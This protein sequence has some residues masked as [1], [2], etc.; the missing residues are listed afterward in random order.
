MCGVR[1]CYLVVEAIKD[2]AVVVGVAH[3]DVE[4]NRGGER[5]SAA[6][7][8]RQDE[9]EMVASL[10]VEG[11]RQADTNLVRSIDLFPTAQ[12]RIRLHSFAFVHGTVRSSSPA[13]A[14]IGRPHSLWRAAFGTGRN[15]LT[16]SVWVDSASYMSECM[17]NE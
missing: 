4:E 10:A 1:K 3:V 2:R 6:I 17:V 13:T 14:H 5:R 11:L 7:E 15:I 12:Y 16:C 9:R 8:R